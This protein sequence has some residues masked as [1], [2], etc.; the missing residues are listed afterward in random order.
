MNIPDPLP[1]SR[2]VKHSP[3]R[4]AALAYGV[5]FLLV[6]LAGFIPGLTTDYRA[7]HVGGHHSDALLLGI[8]Q[9]SMLHN[10][11]HLLY[12]IVG[13]ALAM[14][15]WP[16]PARLY[17]RVGGALYLVLWIYGLIVDKDSM[18]NFVPLNTADDWLHF[19]LGVTMIGLSFL[20]RY[21][22]SV[23]PA[24]SHRP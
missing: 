3:V 21:S 11:V 12:G 16:P 20:P 14:A 1:T 17:L 10:V 15:S 22:P 23:L 19:V 18:A 5:V 9:V 8:F 4:L 2:H 6:G 7:L 13:L 24:A